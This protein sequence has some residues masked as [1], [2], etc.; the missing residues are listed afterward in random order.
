MSTAICENYVDWQS[1]FGYLSSPI[2]LELGFVF[3]A[4]SFAGIPWGVAKW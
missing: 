2:L 1:F 4:G 3:S